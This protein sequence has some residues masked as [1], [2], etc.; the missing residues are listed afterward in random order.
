MPRAILPV[1]IAIVMGSFGAFGCAGHDA[2]STS[3]RIAR[4]DLTD[5]NRAI[6]EYWLYAYDMAGHTSQATDYDSAGNLK[7][8][9]TYSY[10]GNLRTASSMAD[11][12]GE[13]MNTV[14]YTY[15][16]GALSSSTRR[17]SAG[18]VSALYNYVFDAGRKITSFYYMPDNS[19]VTRTEF[20]YDVPPTNKR[21]GSTNYDAYDAITG[22]SLRTYEQ[23]LFT[24]TRIISGAT[25]AYRKFHY[26][27]GP[28]A[29][30]VDD[31][32]E[33]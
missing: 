1:V 26:Q 12:S 2:S 18:T 22:S 13:L 7:S 16:S 32:F 30:D 24:E 17:T 5:A 8:T 10:S 27:D 11:A 31:F 6:T 21:L 20:N 15:S 9:T 4:Q 25:T 29:V 3:Q 28:L 23:G 19:L 14:E 33:F